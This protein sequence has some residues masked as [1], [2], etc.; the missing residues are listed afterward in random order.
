MAKEILSARGLDAALKAAAVVAAEKNTRVKVQDGDNL[1]LIVRPNGGA[2]WVLRYRLKGNRL[3]FTIGAWPDVSLKLARE[4]AA[5]ARALVAA[6]IDPT[7]RRAAEEAASRKLAPSD[8]VRAMFDDWMAKQRVS[9]VYR[10]NIEAAFL[11]D[12]LPAIGAMRPG[13]VTRRDVLDILRKIEA[14]GS[15]DMLRRVRMWMKQLYEFAL[16]DERVPASPVP[17]GHL[18]SVMEHEKGHF[19]AL[20]DPAEVGPLLRAIRAYDKP[21]VRFGLLLSA[22]LWQ[23]PSEIRLAQV[24]EFDLDGAVWIIPAERMKLR[25]EHWVPLSPQVVGM[26]R[27]HVG[28]VG[29]RGWLLPGQRFEKPLSDGTLGKALD[30][31]GYAG[32]MTP[33]GFRAMARTILEERLV[34]DHRFLEKQLAHEETD[35]VKRAYNRSEHWAGRVTMMAT[36]SAWLEAQEVG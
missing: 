14:R 24:E 30:F 12:V 29:P 3:G 35:K 13:E 22:H 2:T 26:L 17:T 4:L 18:K 34:V 32:R 5:K 21:I 9:E 23:R 31:L 25:R 11:K 27:N 36:W 28:V 10:G 8:S 7:A 16:D 19:P 20:T 15:H 33:H 6:G 1:M